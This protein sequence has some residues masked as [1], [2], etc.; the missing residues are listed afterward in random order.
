[1]D[2]RMLGA[3]RSKRD[4][5][6][7]NF[8]YAANLPGVSISSAVPETL[9]LR[10]NLFEVR[11]Q[12]ADGACVGFACACM[13]DF[14]ENLDQN[15]NTTEAMSPLFIYNLRPNKCVNGMPPRVA[16][17]ILRVYG[18]VP[19]S[20]FPYAEGSN[21]SPSKDIIK[22]GEKFR[23]SG[24]AAV[25]TIFGLK[26]S[27]TKNGVCIIV[28]PVYNFGSTFWKP[29]K[30]DALIGYHC[31]SVVGYTKEGFIIRNSWGKSWN[32]NGETI[33]SFNDWGMHVECWTSMDE[34]TTNI[35]KMN[36]I[37][38]MTVEAHSNIKMILLR[39]KSFYISVKSLII[40]LLK[41]K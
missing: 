4:V 5:R 24:Y 27:L 17:D 28:F 34:E 41:K 30:G 32:D 10:N 1:M 21:K 12:G 26:Q 9:D 37:D 36:K 16:L 31:V 38:T 39:I 13:K 35:V 29:N 23:I 40:K 14:Q 15:S 3:V 19:E 20:I 7:F 8:E 22:Q 18:I 2:K 11:D 25:K 33:Y 6:D